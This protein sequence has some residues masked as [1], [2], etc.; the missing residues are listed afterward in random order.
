MSPAP[1]PS[2]S[3]GWQRNTIWF[4]IVLNV[5]FNSAF[6]ISISGI[7]YIIA[8]PLNETNIL[9]YILFIL[10]FW[11]FQLI[12]V[13]PTMIYFRRRNLTKT[14]SDIMIGALLIVLAYSLPFFIL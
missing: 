9:Y 4:G 11:A 8:Y 13:I 12:H 7:Y 10:L 14:A 2:F 1:S 5:I 6:F 3:H